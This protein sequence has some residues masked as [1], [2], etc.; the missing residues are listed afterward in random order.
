MATITVIFKFS[1]SFAP[2]QWYSRG[3]VK[4]IGVLPGLRANPEIIGER[5]ASIE[6]KGNVFLFEYLTDLTDPEHL[7]EGWL[8]KNGYRQESI[9]DFSGVGL[10][11]NYS[12]NKQSLML[13]N[14]QSLI[15][16]K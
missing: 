15:L 13:R 12:R 9:G 6:D 7:V 1:D 14:K 4:A 2:Y 10:I 16:T 8:E 3:R 11:Y 5:M